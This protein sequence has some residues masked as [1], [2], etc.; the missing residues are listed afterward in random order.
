MS[1]ETHCA[2]NWLTAQSSEVG[3]LCGDGCKKPEPYP[4]LLSPW[5]LPRLPGWLARVNE[6]LTKQELDAVRL[7]AQRGK[8]LG[9]EGWVESIAKRLHL[10]STIRPR[11][12][13]RVR[14]PQEETNKDALTPETRKQPQIARHSSFLKSIRFPMWENTENT[15]NTESIVCISPSG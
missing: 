7:P 11:S 13:P 2:L 10:E 5:P 3:D 9:D 6:P 12:R 15:K 4:K 14:F 1:N 8:P